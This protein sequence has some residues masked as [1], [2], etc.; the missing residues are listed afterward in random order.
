LTSS[1]RFF[2]DVIPTRGGAAVVLYKGTIPARQPAFEEVRDDVAADWLAQR[3][4]DL[5][6][7]QGELW[8]EAILKG[9][10]EGRSFKEAAEAQ[11][12]QVQSFADFNA[13]SMPFQLRFWPGEFSMADSPML[14]ARKMN[15]GDVS[16]MR[17][18]GQQGTLLHVAA[19]SIPEPAADENPQEIL[20][21]L[22]KSYSDA[23]GAM[24]IEGIAQRRLQELEAELKAAYEQ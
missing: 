2:S 14:L 23:S 16:Q 8:R 6:V 7:Q 22:Q 24:L 13:A 15:P 1:E 3:K 17:L 12:L 20:A 19:R 10:Q 18:S 11:G 4:R 21:S 5:F 9:M